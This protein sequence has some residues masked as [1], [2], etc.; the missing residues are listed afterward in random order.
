[1]CCVCV[2]ASRERERALGSDDARDLA[3]R[4]IKYLICIHRLFR[5]GM[6]IN[7]NVCNQFYSRLLYR[8]MGAI[9]EEKIWI[10]IRFPNKYFSNFLR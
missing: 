6:D 4:R 1:M 10:E 7:M 2:E 8:L 5:L 9:G 3:K